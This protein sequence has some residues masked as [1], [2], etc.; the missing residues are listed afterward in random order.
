MRV[1][2]VM[3]LLD[4]IVVR[5]VAGQRDAYQPICS[6]LA[7]DADA[8]TVAR[9]FRDR[10]GLTEL[11]VADLD[12]IVHDRP[13][14]S[15]YRCL[16]DDGFDIMVDVGLRD[17]ERASETLAAG[18]SAVI[19]GLEM[20]PGSKLLRELCAAI[21]PERLIFSLDMQDGV[22][23][24]RL[25]SA[26]TSDPWDI[27]LQAIDAGV[28]RM[29][30][31]DLAGVGVDAGVPTQSLCRRLRQEHPRLQ[32]ITGGGV[33]S[34]DDL[35]DLQLLGIDGALV[36]SAL[37]DGMIGRKELEHLAGEKTLERRE[38]AGKSL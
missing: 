17:V 14:T 30:V 19:A 32:L 33:R 16:A 7:E 11:Y 20:S 18:A 6:R 25:S 23:L 24:G 1:L 31:L 5:G 2:P 10:L 12:A 22:P 13:N 3:D 37:H 34:A 15:I 4:G 38:D 21:G 36:A 27:A 26:A 35:R 8:R 9:A 28:T 29:I